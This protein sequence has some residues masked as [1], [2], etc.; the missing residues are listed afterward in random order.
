M[1]KI[2]I[3]T[4][5]QDVADSILKFV[6]SLEVLAANLAGPD[7]PVDLFQ[8]EYN[9]AFM[10]KSSS[11]A[12]TGQP[13]G[14]KK[15]YRAVL[16]SRRADLKAAIEKNLK[17]LGATTMHGIIYNDIVQMTMEN[18]QVIEKD[19]R[20]KRCAGKAG[21]SQRIIGDLCRM[22]IVESVP[23]VQGTE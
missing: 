7:G 8:L 1:A 13:L 12:G 10:P 14:A 4:A 23:I 21:T 9:P 19:I 11:S 15:H 16:P 20:N 2:E 22:G 6:T 3:V 5:R 18:Q 17:N